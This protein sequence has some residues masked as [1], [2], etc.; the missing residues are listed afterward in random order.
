MYDGLDNKEGEKDLYLLARQRD[1][2]GKYLQQVSVIKDRDGNVLI[3][4]ESVLTFWKEYSE[5]LMYGGKLRERRCEGGWNC[6]TGKTAS[7]ISPEALL[8]YFGEDRLTD[9]V[10]LKSLW[11][12]MFADDIVICSESREQGK[13]TWRS[14]GELERRGI[15]VIC[16]KTEYMF[17]WKG[18]KWNGGVRWSRSGKG[19][20][21]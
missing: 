15:K 3:S 17:K 14:G 13:R 7:R 4:Q 16:S 19:Q 6:G 12:M 20:W 10:R 8:V 21:V 1:W 18:G 2:V 9:E 5:E 11:T